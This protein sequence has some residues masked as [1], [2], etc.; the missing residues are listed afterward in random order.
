MA[1]RFTRLSVVAGQQQLDASLPSTRPVAE[2]LADLPAL[3]SLA[4]TTPPT[5]WALSTPRHGQISPE[6]CLDEV[7]VLDGDV[8]YLSPAINA[9]ESPFVEDVLG[10]IASTVDG[11]TPPWRDEHRDRA[12]T[13]LL[14][15]VVVTLA[16]AL[17]AVPQ[18]I[19]SGVTLVVVGLGAVA[20]GT[21]LA[22]RGGAAIRWTVPV[23]TG[24]AAVRFSEGQQLG[25]RWLATV[26]AG[27][28]G[29][30]VMALVQ[31][32][33]AAVV[34]CGT[35]A[36]LAGLTALLVSWHIDAASIAAWASPALVLALGLLP[37]LALSAS[38]LVGMVQRGEDEGRVPRAELLRRTGTAADRID[39]ALVA[40]AFTGAAAVAALVLTGRS[41]QAVLGGLLAL[42]FALRTRGFASVRHVGFL[43]VVPVTGLVAAALA[44]PAWAHVTRPEFVATQRIVGLV[45]VGCLVALAGYVR[46]SPA[47]GARLT[48]ALDLLDTLSIVALI[49]VLLLAQDV[50]GWLAR[51]L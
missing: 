32:R 13:Y 1:T 4:P 48:R 11:R 15:G 35:G 31:R 5:A 40:T 30:A 9:A 22:T 10:T 25:T 6:R 2:F 28:A 19:A 36:V 7:G 38:G 51:K 17:F 20:L 34:G 26:A 43:L 3:F 39:G 16:F 18:R 23:F 41:G 14:A 8:L 47:A 33:Q 49:P 29:V 45:V 46:L 21:Y 37:Q 12:V 42:I 24:L 50:F 27:L 44:L